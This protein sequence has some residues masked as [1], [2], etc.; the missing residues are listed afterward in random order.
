MILELI[1]TPRAKEKVEEA[2]ESRVKHQRGFRWPRRE[3]EAPLKLRKSKILFFSSFLQLLAVQSD[4]SEVSAQEPQVGL[5]AGWSEAAPCVLWAKFRPPELVGRLRFP[6][7]VG[8]QSSSPDQGGGKHC[9]L[10]IEQNHLFSHQITWFSYIKWFKVKRKSSFLFQYIHLQQ[11]TQCWVKKINFSL[12]RF[13]IW[14]SSLPEWRHF[15]Q[16]DLWVQK[17]VCFQEK[18]EGTKFRAVPAPSLFSPDCLRCLLG[19]KKKKK[20]DQT[21]FANHRIIK[22][23]SGFLY[24]FTSPWK[25]EWVFLY[26]LPFLYIENPNFLWNHDLWGGIFGSLA[27]DLTVW[28]QKC[29]CWRFYLRLF[30]AQLFLGK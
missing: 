11:K 8:R 6:T 14:M 1:K 22:F 25:L 20:K 10:R 17:T 5:L 7:D 4:L 21:L 13:H 30:P 28:M 27:F 15:T 18:R 29:N 23:L 9:T 2:A 19:E 24:H 3:G 26:K 16:L 12:L